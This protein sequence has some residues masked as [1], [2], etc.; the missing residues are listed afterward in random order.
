MCCVC[1]VAVALVRSP[2]KGEYWV[3]LAYWTQGCV[4]RQTH[5]QP[6]YRYKRT[7]SQRHA[8]VGNILTRVN[9]MQT[10]TLIKFQGIKWSFHF[11]FTFA[12]KTF[13]FSS[14]FELNLC[15]KSTFFLE[16]APTTPALPKP[17]GL[18]QKWLH[19]KCLNDF[20]LTTIH[21]RPGSFTEIRWVADLSED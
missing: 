13:F 8:A 12:S 5:V 17:A 3:T 2:S 18:R 15:I 4:Q 7:S 14:I 20:V 1:C 10:S 19:V 11:F 16:N 21:H 9:Y 6:C